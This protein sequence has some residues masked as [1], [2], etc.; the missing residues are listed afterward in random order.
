L[1]DRKA[2]DA[3]EPNEKSGSDS[4]QLEQIKRKTELSDWGVN[5][6]GQ[7]QRVA[8]SAPNDKEQDAEYE[9]QEKE[10]DHHISAKHVI[11]R[12]VSR[13][14]EADTEI[15]GYHGAGL[16]SGEN[17]TAIY[18]KSTVSGIGNLHAGDLQT[19]SRGPPGVY[20]I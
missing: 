18:R 2:D 15:S 8:E 6:N 9:Q 10:E 13:S 7:L 20:N 1:L 4:G 19:A 11:Q 3:E 5:K 14:V 16:T 12:Q 17:N